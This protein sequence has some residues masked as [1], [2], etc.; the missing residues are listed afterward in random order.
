MLCCAL[1]S[2]VGDAEYIYPEMVDSSQSTLAGGSEVGGMIDVGVGV[3][4]R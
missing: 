4:S 2:S 3:S 1:Q